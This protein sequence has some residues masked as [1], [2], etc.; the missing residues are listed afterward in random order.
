MP[1]PQLTGPKTGPVGI[2][3]Q[4]QFWVAMY[5]GCLQDPADRLGWICA[6]RIRIDVDVA[7]TILIRWVEFRSVIAFIVLFLR[8]VD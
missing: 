3:L 1:L 6:K 8:F 2:Q 7:V 5:R 4:S